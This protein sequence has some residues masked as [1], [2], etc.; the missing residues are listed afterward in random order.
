M[1]TLARVLTGIISFLAIANNSLAESKNQRY[2][3]CLRNIVLNATSLLRDEL[4]YENPKQLVEINL[5]PLTDG[6]LYQLTINLGYSMAIDDWAGLAND[7]RTRPIYEALGVKTAFD[8][9][10]G[11]PII[12]QMPNAMAANARIERYNID[13]PDKEKIAIRFFDAPPSEVKVKRYLQEWDQ[14]GAI[15]L[16]R[17]S[18]FQNVYGGAFTHDHYHFM[19]SIWLPAQAIEVNRTLTHFALE[20]AKRVESESDKV[21]RREFEF[22]ESRLAGI[23]DGIS[24]GLASPTTIAKIG[25]VDDLV[26][27]T[28]GS[29]RLIDDFVKGNPSPWLIEAWSEFRK[30]LEL[31][32]EEQLLAMTNHIFENISPKNSLHIIDLPTWSRKFRKEYSDLLQDSSEHSKL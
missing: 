30:T 12:K 7:I 28:Y 2:E 10:L 9:D 26:K 14:N 8:A 17:P 18:Y 32:S 16:S 5:D 23:V 4:Q 1:R 13:K 25:I 27:F 24:G 20:I 29:A 22:L 31:P 15:P 3:R 6:W 21:T 11:K 19:S